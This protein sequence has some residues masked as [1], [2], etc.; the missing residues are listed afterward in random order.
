MLTVPVVVMR[1][2]EL[3]PGLANHRAPSGPA[4]IPF[5]LSPPLMLASMWLVT[6]PPVV[7]RPIEPFW[8][9]VNQR[10]PSAPGA[11]PSGLLMPVPV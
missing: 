11:M 5:Q 8:R 6:A 7:M 4:V 3:L 2:I 9:L 1:P 10:A